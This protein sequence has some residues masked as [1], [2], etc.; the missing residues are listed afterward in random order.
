MKNRK[1][2]A[3]KSSNVGLFYP[4]PLLIRKVAVAQ[5]LISET[6]IVSSRLPHLRIPT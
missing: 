5:R 2:I 3:A 1:P 4:T 6:I